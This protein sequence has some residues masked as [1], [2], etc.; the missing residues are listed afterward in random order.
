M[1]KPTLADFLQGRAGSPYAAPMS[2]F[3]TPGDL[4]RERI[5]NALGWDVQYPGQE[6][7]RRAL[8]QLPLAMRPAM[9]GM[10]AMSGMPAQPGT[11]AQPDSGVPPYQAVPGP[12]TPGHME[13]WLQGRYQPAARSQA[14][15][16]AGSVGNE[17]PSF[18]WGDVVAGRIRVPQNRAEMI[19]AAKGIGAA[20]A[21]GGVGSAGGMY[22]T[23]RLYHGR[24]PEEASWR[25]LVG[26]FPSLGDPPSWWPQ[27]PSDEK[28]LPP[29]G[30]QPPSQLRSG[31]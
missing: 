3:T 22:L 14:R 9:G 11:A 15:Q 19:E 24:S 26:P 4:Q 2:E 6:F 23:D 12:W 28:P 31:W 18:T 10:P 16:P 29:S 13:Q 27:P 5:S 21:A 17:A 20:S 25:A 7:A 8:T 1:T 30:P